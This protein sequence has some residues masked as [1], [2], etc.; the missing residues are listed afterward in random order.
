LNDG[1]LL[2]EG[3]VAGVAGLGYNG[4][5]VEVAD[6]QCSLYFDTTYGGDDGYTDSLRC[7]VTLRDEF[8]DEDWGLADAPAVDASTQVI[9]AFIAAA[10]RTVVEQV[11]RQRS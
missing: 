5:L 7:Y 3:I 10:T 2:G 4:V 6:M 11:L 8:A 1:Q 9:A